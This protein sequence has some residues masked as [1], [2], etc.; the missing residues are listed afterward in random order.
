[1]AEHW[2]WGL[3]LLAVLVWYSA[4]TIYVA[5]RGSLDIRQMLRRL[6]DRNAGGPNERR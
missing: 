3:L 2:F 4:M 5:V 1:M 6:S